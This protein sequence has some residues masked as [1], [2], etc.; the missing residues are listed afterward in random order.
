MDLQS[1]Q[2]QTVKVVLGL[3]HLC[4]ASSKISPLSWAALLAI[5]LK[6]WDYEPS[7]WMIFALCQYKYSCQNKT[8]IENELQVSECKLIQY[9]HT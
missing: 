7:S 3:N 5:Q 1:K 9:F 8:K 2:Y 6:Y 4:I